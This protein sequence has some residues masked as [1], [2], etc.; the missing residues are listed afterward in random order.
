MDMAY[1]GIF[2][3][4]QINEIK[5]QVLNE[6]IA[7]INETSNKEV[8]I[9]IRKNGKNLILTLSANPNFP[10][11]LLSNTDSEKFLNPPAFCMLLRKYLQG[12]LIK[13][14]KQIGGKVKTDFDASNYL[15]RIV[16][17]EIENINDFGEKKVYHL[18]IEIMG[19]YSNIIITDNDYIILDVRRD[20]EYA[21]GHIPGAINVAN[22]D[23]SDTEP[24][25]LPDKTQTIYVYCR[26]GNRSKQASEKL[27]ALGYE[28]IIE[29]GGIMDWTGDIEN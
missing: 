3:K 10:H 21:E 16:D 22:E 18:L 24:S 27:A 25:E 1:D 8:D 23:I 2:I 4:A 29:F 13:D 14:I 5:K 28:N 6:H 15:E 20:D 12:G 19:K 26:S 17:I 9:F 11:I 7:R